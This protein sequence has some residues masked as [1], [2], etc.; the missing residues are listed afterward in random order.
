[1]AENKTSMGDDPLAWLTEGDHLS[2]TEPQQVAQTRSR[3]RR[4]SSRRKAQ[5]EKTDVELLE[6]SFAAIAPQGDAL[7]ARFYERLFEHYPSVIPLFSG[8]SV[9]EQQKKLLAA[10]VLLVQN[11]HKPDVL[12]EYLKGLGARHGHYGVVAE[13]YPLVAENLLAVMEEFAGD[14]WT[15][16]VKLAW[17]N[18]IDTIATIMLQA[19]EPMEA[20]EMEIKT[21]LQADKAKTETELLEESF[22]ALA[23]QGNALAKRFYERLFEK[24]P[25]VIPLFSGVST[26]E[27]QKKLLAALVLLVQNL[28]KPDVLSEY[29]KGLGARHVKYGVTAEHYPLVAENLLSVM[30]EFAGDLWVPAVAQAWGNTLNTVATIM[31]QA[32]EPVE[33]DEMAKENEK[34]AVQELAMMKSAV[35]GS[36]TST[37]MIDRD[38]NITYVNNATVVMLTP[39]VD[40][41]K[42][43]FPGFD[44]ENLI[45]TNIDIFHKNPAHQR[46][47][48]SDPTNCPYVTDIQVGPLRFN[49]NVTAMVDNDGNYLGNTLEWAN[50]TEVRAKESEVARLSAT[51]DGAMTSIM[52]INRDFEITYINDSTI[53]MLRPYVDTLKQVFPGFDLD[54]LIG[55]N[56]DDF[57]KDP[58]HQRKLLSDPKNL[59]YQTDITVGPLKFNLNVTAMVDPHGE[60]IGNALEWTNVTDVRIK[61][62]AVTRLQGTIDGAKTSIMM[63]DRDFFVTYA[64]KSTI[65]ML[66]E[67][68]DTLRSVFPGFDVAKLVGTNIDTFHKNPAHQRK[69]LSDPANLPYNTDIEVGPLSFNLNVT[70]I[71][72]SEGAYIGTALEW[73]NNTESKNTIAAYEGQL[74]AISKAM[75]VI[76]FEMDGTIIDVNQ[77]FLDVVGYTKEEVVGN[78]HRMF[79]E[80]EL[81][82]S[83]EYR[84]FWAKL[85]RGEFDSGEYKRVAKSGKIVYL[86]ASYNPIIDINGKPVRVIKYAANITEQ[87]E[88]Q[89]V[90]E[91]VL[92]G[93]SEV[94]NAMSQGDLTK[95][96]IGDYEGPFALLQTAINSTVTK[97]SETVK[98]INETA[99]SIAMASSEISEGNIDLSQRTEE[100]AS[101]L[102][103]TASSMEELTSTVRQN[104]DNARQANQLASNAREQAEKGGSVIKSAISAMIAIS[105]SS[106]KVTDIIGV[107]DEIAFQTNLLALNAAVEA[108]RA[109][110]QGRGFAVVAS[111]VRNL[112]QRSA[113]AAKEIKELINDSGEKVKEGSMLVDE[114]GRTLEEIVIGAKK[115]GDII[116][117][118]AAAGAEQ[119]Q[120]IEQVNKAVTQ[121]DEMTQQNAALVE[122]AAAASESLEEQGK[123][124]QRLMTF[125]TTGGETSAPVAKKVVAKAKPASAEP[126][127][128]AA[129]KA[130]ASAPKSSGDDEWDEF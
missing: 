91:D 77:N 80:A 16:Q 4:D 92:A 44:L 9:A 23:P 98:E 129:P 32:Y 101:S 25:A 99:S 19:Y 81:A 108:A 89:F 86:Q 112:A 115:V 22:A 67:Y 48:L 128:T 74:D 110:E 78:H 33:A 64:N 10:L 46:K 106:K 11:L 45:G 118:I 75:G 37:M 84:E 34:G 61:E 93:T 43:V 7:A 35:N 26:G 123:G 70:A 120:G 42:K 62:A 20:D 52:M 27:Q 103:E 114:S 130:R 17:A 21:S 119:T 18:T 6:E 30:E 28:H 13:H 109:G 39:Y 41:L 1:M 29:L 36:M 65:D 40:T 79:A 38:F 15:T 90:I 83:A 71:Y 63:I 107:I 59:P 8:S 53:N 102:E 47:L 85:N 95:Q 12:S 113:S 121:M 3:T 116:S 126:R 14:L 5:Q 49:L 100:Q 51:V 68:Q 87:K 55:K 72:D 111:E 96:L 57:H 117:E 60:Y 97:I 88:L 24:Y 122:Q 54:N 66:T 104:S 73:L 82:N 50:V 125:F 56:I 76:S 2:K 124:L 105:A 94:M 127:A 58:S 31:L 69:L